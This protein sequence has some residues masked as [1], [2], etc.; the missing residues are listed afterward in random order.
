MIA[1]ELD[2]THIVQFLQLSLETY[3]C[4]LVDIYGSLIEQLALIL[5]FFLKSSVPFLSNLQDSCH[6]IGQLVK[7]KV[8][9]IGDEAV[10][11]GTEI[12]NIEQFAAVD[13]PL[14]YDIL[15]GL[16]DLDQTGKAND[17]LNRPVDLALLYQLDFLAQ[18]KD[19]VPIEGTRKDQTHL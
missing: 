11:I 2:H 4:V 1:A 14:H 18:A 6:N 7:R 10:Q 19:V 17:V 12:L 15:D 13:L 5:F 16:F 9:A 3:Y 8:V